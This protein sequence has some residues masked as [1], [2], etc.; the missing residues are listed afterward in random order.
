MK[1]HLCKDKSCYE[2]NPCKKTDSISLYE[3]ELDRKLL[4]V[5]ADVEALFYKQICR[6]DE[7]IEFARRMGFKK[8]GL[9]FCI[10]V[11]ME[12]KT[13][14]EI[15]SEEFDVISVC[16]KVGSI[17]KSEFGMPSRPWIGEHSCNPIEQARILDEEG[18]EFNIVFGLCVGHDSLFYRHSKAP[19]T[20]LFTKDRKLGHNAVAALYCPYLRPEL[21]K[22]LRERPLEGDGGVRNNPGRIR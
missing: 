19:V 17:K 10:G 2:G 15:L 21:G 3:D 12:A 7:T 4:T 9:A 11:A 6:V 22:E 18:S 16:C 14:G 13:L 1:C 8:I 20:T 5:A